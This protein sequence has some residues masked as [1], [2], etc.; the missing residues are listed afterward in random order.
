[1][2]RYSKCHMRDG[3]VIDAI[4]HSYDVEKEVDS[5]FGSR[6]V[7]LFKS[8]RAV[9]L[10]L[11]PWWCVQ[12]RSLLVAGARLYHFCLFLW[13]GCG[14][15]RTVAVAV[16]FHNPPVRQC[17]GFPHLAP[18]AQALAS[19]EDRLPRSLSS[20]QADWEAHH[21]R[22]STGQPALY[23]PQWSGMSGIHGWM[24]GYPPPLGSPSH[25]AASNC[26]WLSLIFFARWVNAKQLLE[27]NEGT[28]LMITIFFVQVVLRM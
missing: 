10:G 8:I 20:R 26:R 12:Q 18:F 22:H 16:P 5:R 11:L 1:M 25:P 9:T 21:S 23:R 14:N 27:V 13:R 28:G 4:T 3:T 6:G 24:W 17:P 2:R 7:K 15:S 19:R